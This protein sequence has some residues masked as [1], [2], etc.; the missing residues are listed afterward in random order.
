METAND[1]VESL[2][3][4]YDVARITGV[5]LGSIRR[6]RLL[7]QGPKFLKLGASVRYRVNDLEA[8]LDARPTGGSEIPA[9]TSADI[10]RTSEAIT[11]TSR[12]RGNRR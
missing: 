12:K 7:R 1:G 10:G 5:S 4:E 8:W 2:L 9:G 3:N 6:W 11:A